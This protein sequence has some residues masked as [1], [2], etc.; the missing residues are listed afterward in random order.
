MQR[1]DGIRLLEAYEL[2]QEDLDGLGRCTIE[3]LL[4]AR[5]KVTTLRDALVQ[6]LADADEDDAPGLALPD[7]EALR[8]EL[9][10]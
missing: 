2:A 4:A 1:G 8:H 3:Q 6:H 10:R 5:L 7:P 9:G